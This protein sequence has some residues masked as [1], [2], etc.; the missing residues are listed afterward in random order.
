MLPYLSFWNKK[1]Y[2][3]IY[4]RQRIPHKNL[5]LFNQN[6]QR[7]FKNLPFIGSENF[8]QCCRICGLLI[9]GR[10]YVEKGKKNCGK[11]VVV[12]NDGRKFGQQASAL[13][14]SKLHVYGWFDRNI[15]EQYRFRK[16][17]F[18]Q[19]C[20]P[21]PMKKITRDDTSCNLLSKQKNIQPCLT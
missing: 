20:I 10:K 12:Q 6:C 8:F 16:T 5:D 2:L 9:V 18:A 13:M 17:P 15:V 1:A 19:F 11:A 21:A 4:R 7:R 14:V 3:Q